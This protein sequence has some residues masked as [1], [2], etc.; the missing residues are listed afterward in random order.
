MKEIKTNS[1]AAEK[2]AIANLDKSKKK[3]TQKSKSNL[4]LKES[5]LHKK[6]EQFKKLT[7]RKIVKKE[8]AEALKV[9]TAKQL[10]KQLTK[11]KEQIEAASKRRLKAFEKTYGEAT[12]E[13]R[14]LLT[15]ATA[16]QVA[17]LYSIEKL[18]KTKEEKTVV[19][20]VAETTTK[21]EAKEKTKPDPVLLSEF[22][23]S[24]D[25][26]PTAVKQWSHKTGD[27]LYEN[28]LFYGE[29]NLE[30]LKDA[31]DH[32]VYEFFEEIFSGIESLKNYEF[33]P[34]NSD[35]IIIY[36]KDEWKEYDND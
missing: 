2:A 1:E 36:N 30:N 17:K 11:T 35:N 14:K 25:D 20:E 32:T 29:I 16:S 33:D 26:L 7:G 4:K 15:Y 3:K 23:I 19:E 34:E 12:E 28:E 21:E 8:E 13:Q 6:K 5:K 31:N 27:F 22:S 9:I 18:G 10:A 24:Y